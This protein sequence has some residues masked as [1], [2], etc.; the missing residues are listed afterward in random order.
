MQ[1]YVYAHTKPDGTIFYIGKGSNKRAYQK[2]GRNPHWHNVVNKYGYS[3]V[4]LADQLTEVEAFK[5]E[6]DLIKHF[7][8]FGFLVNKTLGGEGISGA[9]LPKWQQ[10][11][12]TKGVHHTQTKEYSQ[13]RKS[14][15]KIA[16]LNGSWISPMLNPEYAKKQSE[17]KKNAEL[18][19]CPKCKL[20][21]KKGSNMTRYHF[22]NCKQYLSKATK[23]RRKRERALFLSGI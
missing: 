14:I 4:I 20:T 9:K 12:V 19:T 23:N 7:N 16:V 6:I 10:E 2:T 5:E 15:Q 11:R 1:H 3:V 13:K 8:V 22:D 18:I 17:T 21:K